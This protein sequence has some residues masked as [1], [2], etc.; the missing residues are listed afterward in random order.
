MNA[1]L[2][3][4][5]RLGVGALM[6]ALFAAGCASTAPSGPPTAGN[7]LLGTWRLVSF[8]LEVQGQSDKVLMMGKTPAGY[9]SFLPDG[10][11]A[12]VITAEGRKPGNV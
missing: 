11:M 12:V 4:L 5:K 10:R 9:L 3:V 2:S 1:M 8:E 7:P 6:F